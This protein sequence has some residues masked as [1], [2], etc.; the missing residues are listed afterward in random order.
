MRYVKQITSPYDAYLFKKHMQTHRNA[1]KNVQPKI[2]SKAPFCH[3]FENAKKKEIRKNNPT[4][5]HRRQRSHSS[6]STKRTSLGRRRIR[7]RTLKNHSKSVDDAEY[8]LNSVKNEKALKNYAKRSK[9]KELAKE[10][11]K[12]VANLL[13]TRPMIDTREPQKL[14]QPLNYAF[15][16]NQANHIQK[17]NLKVL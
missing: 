3:S 7:H 5:H 12:I 2:D 17:Q 14:L 15:R 4:K 6:H 16:K 9:E 10:N 13:K 8:K 1:I 11:Q